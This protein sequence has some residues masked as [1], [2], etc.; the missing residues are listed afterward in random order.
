MKQ[1]SRGRPH[2]QPVHLSAPLRPA[3]REVFGAKPMTFSPWP[4]F[5]N[6]GR[7]IGLNAYGTFLR[8]TDQGVD[9]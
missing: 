9:R 6:Y 5:P 3:A 1:A 4:V 2:V 8:L 7:R